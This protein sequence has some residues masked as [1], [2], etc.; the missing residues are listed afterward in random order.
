LDDMLKTAI[1]SYNV[2]RHAISDA[3][4]LVRPATMRGLPPDNV[5]IL[6]NGKRRHRSGVIAELGGSLAAGSQGADISAIPALAIKQTEVL[7][8]GASAQYGSDAIA[9]VMNFVIFPMFFLSSALY[10][11]W[12]M[13][14]SS[15]L[16]FWICTLNPFTYAV[17]L[18]RHA[19]YLKLNLQAL[20]IVISCLIVVFVI[21]IWQYNTARS[22]PRAVK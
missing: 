20:T 9:G 4:T 11:L 3:A 15:E 1:P 7:R 21:A 17:E 16:I 8:D 19:I 10:P 12:R 18:V 14:E 13:R 5:L 2:S 22:R 6:V